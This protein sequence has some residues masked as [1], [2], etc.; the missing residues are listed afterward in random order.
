MWHL[1]IDIP[2]IYRHI[3]RRR[4]KM[5]EMVMKK[6]VK[7]AWWARKINQ[8]AGE[9]S[10]RLWWEHRVVTRHL[11]DLSLLSGDETG[12]VLLGFKLGDGQLL[13]SCWD[14]KQATANECCRKQLHVKIIIIILDSAW[15]LNQCVNLSVSDFKFEYFWLWWPEWKYWK[16]DSG[17]WELKIAA[18]TAVLTRFHPHCSAK[19][20]SGDRKKVSFSFCKPSFKYS[21]WTFWPRRD[22]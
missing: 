15:R 11:D 16:S 10:A 2:H 3:Y 7:K 9:R 5:M 8:P 13:N 21:L 4:K 22:A 1:Y 14:R 12:F 18:L 6:E 17:F 20:T 19:D